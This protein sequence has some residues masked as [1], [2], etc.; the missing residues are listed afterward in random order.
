V[1]ILKT[2]EVAVYLTVCL[3]T[4]NTLNSSNHTLVLAGMN[5]VEFSQVMMSDIAPGQIV[6]VAFVENKCAIYTID[7]Q[8]RPFQIAGTRD[9]LLDAKSFQ[10]LTIE[11]R[12]TI[13]DIQFI[14]KQVFTELTLQ[15]MTACQYLSAWEWEI[16][17]AIVQEK[18]NFN[19][20]ISLCQE[21]LLQLPN[22]NLSQKLINKLKNLKRPKNNQVQEQYIDWGDYEIKSQIEKAATD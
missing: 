2:E 12:R 13:F 5:P 15:E 6:I 10:D 4:C 8:H 3:K 17:E 16:K 1:I 21:S 7:S 20:M 18:Y 9:F 19:Q 22:S 11:Y 14:L